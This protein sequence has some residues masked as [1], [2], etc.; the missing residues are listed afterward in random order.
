MIDLCD[1]LATK[2]DTL[3]SDSKPD[4]EITLPLRNDTQGYIEVCPVERRRSC[5][6]SKNKK[7]TRDLNELEQIIFSAIDNRNSQP[8]SHP[9][10]AYAGIRQ[11]VRALSEER[12]Y[13]AAVGGG[14]SD[15]END[16][17]Q[18]AICRNE[19][20]SLPDYK[21]VLSHFNLKVFDR[22]SEKIPT[23]EGQAIFID[24]LRAKSGAQGL[25][26][27][28]LSTR[29]ARALEP[30]LSGIA[31]DDQL[32]ELV[33]SAELSWQEVE[34]LR[35]Y[36]A[37]AN[38][39]GIATPIATIHSV[40]CEHPDAA[41]LLIRFFHSRFRA[42]L[43]AIDANDR[44]QLV[45][46]SEKALLHYLEGITQADQDR[47]IRR[48]LNQ[49][50]STLRTNFWSR[51]NSANQPLSFKIDCSMVE[52]MPAP[53]PYREIW[54]Q[55]GRIQGV[56][57]RGGAVARGGLRWSDRPIDFRSEILALMQTQM[58]KNVLIVPVGA[59]GGFVLCDQYNSYDES[60]AAADKFYEVFIRG[61]LDIT[62][63]VV[64][65]KVEP[66]ANVVRYD[67][68]DPYLVVA[69]DKGTA[70]LS[71]TA[72]RVAEE[73]NFWLGD[74]FASGGSRGYNHKQWGI[75]AKGAWA[76]VR[77]H[78]AHLDLDPEKDV[79]Q[80]VG[81]GDMSGDV[82]G[83][84]MLLSR[85]IKLV[86][87]F[88]HRHIILDP[89]PDPA[90]SWLERKRLFEL[91]RS[92]WEDYDPNL[93]SAGGGVFSRHS[94]FVFISP[95]MQSLLGIHKRKVRPDT[96]ISAI[97]CCNAD[98]L[99]IGGIGTYVKASCETHLDADDS[100]NDRVRVNANQLR[101]RV[102]GEG[103]NLG[104][105]QAARIEFAAGGGF[106]NADSLDNSAGVD[107]SDHEVNLK[108]LLSSLERSGDF[109]REERDQL[110][111]KAA[112][113]I[114]TRVQSNNRRHAW[115]V[116]LDV[117]RSIDQSDD[118]RE[119][120]SDLENYGRLKRAQQVLPE[121]N[122]L[123]RRKLNGEQLTR[124]ELAKLA[125]LV[126]MEVCEALLADE[127]FDTPYIDQWLINYFPK[128]IRERFEHAILNH[129]LRRE[130][131]AM[132]ITNTL[133]DSMGV[134]HFSRL[135]SVTRCEPLEIA[136]TSLLAIDLLDAW[137]LKRILNDLQEV[138]VTLVNLVL[139]QLEEKIAKVT[140]QIL[141]GDFE[142][143]V[144]Q[145]PVL[146]GDNTT[147]MNGW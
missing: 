25:D 128:V 131:A 102:I 105:T 62:D 2:P 37:Y 137:D 104:L 54:I 58:A 26:I 52:N 84:G 122:E 112:E 47:I 109:D 73:Y 1:K 95:V 16:V 79:I 100:S 23:N 42:E 126:K 55:H 15:T 27:E 101:A 20:S 125:P 134:T 121:D 81:I 123:V 45:K 132:M 127:R 65:G 57:L 98:L 64:D 97:L 13:L 17:F 107:M 115:M 39:L 87:A 59:K 67:G 29:F 141:L 61:L 46:D 85:T 133:V 60:R 35:A 78:F 144:K 69:A 72:N 91:P 147:L 140:E 48:T 22:N 19:N 118:F 34:V 74:A 5:S 142:S 143:I 119:L 77:H 93:I 80:T 90:I 124:P 12:P 44:V 24:L 106:I 31:T 96:L 75:T 103:G 43:G 82:F 110:L 36:I 138:P 28:K 68:D 49:V 41:A 88:D 76:C 3:L 89:D 71:D 83:N 40:W 136:Y 94:K 135:Q 145:K 99:W 53:C 33:L 129:P 120:L 9:A 92:S 130:I 111:R 32:N 113:E 139:C 10:Q 63:N 108:I 4:R 117:A 14:S 116:S 114:S 11:I 18:I 146:T 50:M 51:I 7:S 6:P 66:P 86:A 8:K 21:E 70:N 30:I 38:Q 56:H